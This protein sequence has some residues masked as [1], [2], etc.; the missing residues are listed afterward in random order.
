MYVHYDNI[1][2]FADY[3]SETFGCWTNLAD[4][5]IPWGKDYSANV[6]TCNVVASLLYYPH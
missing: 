5:K 6:N 4:P 3:P 1:A 2:S